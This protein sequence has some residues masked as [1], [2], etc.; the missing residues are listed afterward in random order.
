MF[1]KRLLQWFDIFK[2]SFFYIYITYFNM[3]FSY[4][5]ILKYAIL[6]WN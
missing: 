1:M 2:Q 3:A 6:S 5:E 4:H